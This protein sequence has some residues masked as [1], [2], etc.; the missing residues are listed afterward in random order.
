MIR[1]AL[2]KQDW[3]KEL[4]GAEKEEILTKVNSIA[5]KVGKDQFAEQTGTEYEKYK[6]GGV[7]GLLE[8]FHGK[9]AKNQVEQQTGLSSQSNASKAIVEQVEK[10]NTEVA[11][12]MMKDAKTI[13][14]YGLTKPGATE[15]YQKAQKVAAE[16]GET[17]SVDD[18]AKTYMAIDA[19]HNQGIKQDELIAYFNKNKVPEVQGMKM[20]KMFAPD[21]KKV[22]YIKEDGTWGKH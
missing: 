1:T 9:S 19:D 10:G 17:L 7:P 14:D 5:D 21:G 4:P 15:T 11:Q 12:Q 13:A 20:W 22:P 3:F 2:A 18:F 6:E 8:Y 16:N